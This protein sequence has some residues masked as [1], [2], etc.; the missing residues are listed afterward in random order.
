MVN[1]YS[2]IFVL[3]VTGIIFVGGA[4]VLSWFLRPSKYNPDKLST[5]ECGEKP[6]GIAW[7][8]YNVRFYIY[9]MLFVVFDVETVFI[10]PWAVIFKSLG[11][12]A[13]IEMIIF[14]FILF[15]ALIYAWRKGALEWV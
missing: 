15:V 4:F 12:F 9:A 5:Y 6:K 14:L 13:L 2:Y 11:V 10:I 1:D 3:L 7:V 8:Q